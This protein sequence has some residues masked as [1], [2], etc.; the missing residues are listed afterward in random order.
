VINKIR[1]VG[2]LPFRSKQLSLESSFF[3][4]VVPLLLG[5]LLRSWLKKNFPGI[6]LVVSLP[7]GE[8]HFSIVKVPEVRQS[9]RIPLNGSLSLN[10][11]S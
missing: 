4:E 7:F 5:E 1:L 10:N 3:I 9:A 6:I 11:S 8:L 2:H